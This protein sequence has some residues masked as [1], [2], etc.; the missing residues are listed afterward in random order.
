MNNNPLKQYFRSPAI[1]FKLPSDGKYYANGV[2][3]FPPNREL[4]VYPMTNNDEIAIK[5]PDGIYNGAA[6]VSVI[7]NCVPNI[8]D[9]WALNSIDIEAVIVAIR[10]ASLNGEMEITSTCPKCDEEHKYGINLMGLLAEKVDIDYSSA[11]SIG[12]LDIKFRPL[13]YKEVNENGL[14]QFEVQRLMFNIEAMDD[15]AKKKELL[16]GAVE[17]LNNMTLDVITQSISS[18]KT[19]ETTVTEKEYIRE[20]LRE[21]DS[22]T[23]KTIRER[24]A[25]LKNKNDTRP[26][27]MICHGCQHPYDQQLVLNFTDFFE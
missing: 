10:A 24:V 27:K 3:D 2:V 8:R 18:I 15:E 22:K 11:L 4:P 19:P 14:R 25:S 9:P 13:T 23:N 20:Y 6:V 26:L 21:C 5:T 16:N 1:Y 7:K 17:K 12:E